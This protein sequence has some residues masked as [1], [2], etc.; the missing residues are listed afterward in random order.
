MNKFNWLF[1][2]LISCC[3]IPACTKTVEV[4]RWNDPI[5]IE[6]KCKCDCGS[7]ACKCCPQV[8]V[9]EPSVPKPE[10]PD[11]LPPA[12]PVVVE[13]PAAAPSCSDG[14]CG[15]S[16]SGGSRRGLFRGFF[17]RR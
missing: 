13:P 10:T 17:R 15:Q 7:A 8:V 14:S 11:S 6:A 3:F 9:E 1:L 4:E 16:S 12:P 2:A 5:V